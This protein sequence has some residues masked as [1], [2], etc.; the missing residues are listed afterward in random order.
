MRK[1]SSASP[2]ARAMAEKAKALARV[3]EKSDRAKQSHIER[4]QKSRSPSTVGV[5]ADAVGGRLP[6]PRPPPA[7]PTA[8]PTPIV[9]PRPS[10][11]PGRASRPAPAGE[12][13]AEA[14]GVGAPRRR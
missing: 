14:E 2:V 12:R 11:A 8:N 13:G 3:Q 4:T 6:A 7:R 9:A 1:K 10:A 5:D